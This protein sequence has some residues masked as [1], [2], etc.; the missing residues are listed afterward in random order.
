MEQQLTRH[1]VLTSPSISEQLYSSKYRFLYELIQNAD[2]STFDEVQGCSVSPFLRFEVRPDVLIVETNEDG[3]KRKNIEAICAT[4]K[5]SKKATE[6]DDHI[7][8]KGFGFKSVFSV[9]DE[10][11]I[12]SGLWS[13]R[14][15]HHQGEDGLGMVTP[16]DAL[17]EILPPDVKTRITLRYSNQA[18]QDYPRLLEATHGLPETTIFFLRRLKNIHI[19]VTEVNGECVRTS[20]LRENKL[21]PLRRVITCSRVQDQSS[22]SEECTYL[23]FR[24]KKQDMPYH[25][26]RKHRREAVVELAFPINSDT[27][28]PKPSSSGQHVFAFLPVRRVVQLQVSDYGFS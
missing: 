8:E 6:I 21:S 5:S 26:R 9:A 17:P 22:T 13:F 23:L 24:S 11:K 2:D 7:G 1:R 19:N 3:F 12:Q 20:F 28:Q 10:V 18:K 4:G 25:E 14:F 16:L 15:E 27:H